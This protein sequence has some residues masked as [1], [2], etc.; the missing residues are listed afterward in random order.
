MDDFEETPPG[1][2]ALNFSQCHCAWCRCGYSFYFGGYQF[3][4]QMVASGVKRGCKRRERER[5]DDA[6]VVFL[7]VR[8]LMDEA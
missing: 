4:W 7:A 6:R 8:A 2:A 3:P 5:C 1:P